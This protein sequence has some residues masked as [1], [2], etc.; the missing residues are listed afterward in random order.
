MTRRKRQAENDAI[1]KRLRVRRMTRGDVD[2]AIELATKQGW[3]PGIHDAECFYAADPDGFFVGE[4]DGEP[5]GCVSAVAYSESFGIMGLYIVKPKFRG[6]GLGSRM[7][8]KGLAY[9]EGRNVGGDSVLQ[10]EEYYRRYG[11]RR[12]HFSYR[13]EGVGG[14][15][16]PAGVVDISQVPFDDLAVYDAAVFS[17]PRPRFLKCWI[18]QPEGRALA[19]V[20]NGRL[21]GYGVIRRC[22]KGYKIAP[23]FADDP[24]LAQR[25]FDALRSHALGKPVFMDTPEPNMAA[26]A[27]AA[28]HKMKVVFQTLRTYNKGKPPIPLERVYG[29]TSFE[30]G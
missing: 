3:N 24:R 5:I 1:L 8:E 25:L 18:D 4:L 23:L 28:R 14:G 17:C 12:A 9:L 11:F 26:V 20:E 27:L 10:Q 13:Y 15:S 7:I 2:F 6:M 22:R 16:M 21:A 30:L 29:M 19:V